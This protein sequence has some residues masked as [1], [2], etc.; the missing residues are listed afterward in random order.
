MTPEEV[1]AR[2]REDILTADL[3]RTAERPDGLTMSYLGR[4]HSEA[5]R[6]LRGEPKGPESDDRWQAIRGAY[7][8]DGIE[9]AALKFGAGTVEVERR[10]TWS[11][12]PDLPPI[13]GAF[14]I[15]WFGD[16]VLLDLKTKTKADCRSLARN[17]HREPGFFMQVG[18]LAA[19]LA[20]ERK[21][22]QAFAV[23]VAIDGTFEDWRCFEV[24]IPYW[25]AEAAR[26]YRDVQEAARDPGM[27]TDDVPRDVPAVLCASRCGF[28]ETCRAGYR[29]L[30]IVDDPILQEA[31]WDLFDARR[32]KV[33]AEADEKASLAALGRACGVAPP[34]RGQGHSLRVKQYDVKESDGRAGYTAVKVD[35]L[36]DDGRVVKPEAP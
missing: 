13:S 1:L 14:D 23:L 16:S 7:L 25:S 22:E 11:P 3:L 18:G 30:E 27:P 9:A 28:F 33:A 5:V 36:D 35:L 21:V 26:W 31:A 6:I 2:L 32:I 4:C 17:P 24:D 15:G 8:H 10:V 20:A 29:Q 34:R 12:W 19:A